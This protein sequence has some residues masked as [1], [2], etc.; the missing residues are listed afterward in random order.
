LDKDEI[1]MTITTAMIKELRKVTGAGL[2]DC[3]KAIQAN[4]GDFEKAVNTLRE[5][6]WSTAA[7]KAGQETRAGLVIVKERGDSICAVQVSCETDFVAR[8]DDFIAFTRR[9]TDQVLDDA[10]LTDAEKVLA[11]DFIPGKTTADAIQEMITKLGENI[12]IRGVARYPL[13][14]A[15]TTVEGYIHAGTLEGDYGPMEGRIGVLV[16][17]GT[18]NATAADGNTL[19]GLAHDL[20]LHIANLN[21]GYVSPDDIPDGVIQKER[22]TLMAQLAEENKP[23]PIKAQ[24]VEGRLNKFYQDV[25]LTKQAFVKDDDVSIEELLLQKSKEIGGT[26]TINR[27]VRFEASY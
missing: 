8:T 23:D 27:F 20:A 9:I 21:P 16:E 19:R 7:Q 10:S 6:G 26:I 24:V 5:K 4:G 17:L 2:L 13:G 3:T 14:K 11:A 18:N 12:I 15:G 22:E 1:R 25:C